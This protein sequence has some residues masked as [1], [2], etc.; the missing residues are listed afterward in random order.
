MKSFGSWSGR[1][2][3]VG[4]GGLSSLCSG[5][6]RGGFG[7][8]GAGRYSVAKRG[9]CPTNL[10]QVKENS[11]VFDE[12]ECRECSTCVDACPINALEKED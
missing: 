12:S 1:L 8:F 3:N 7:P 2:D 6:R 10:I 11:L 5:D 4:K 9:V